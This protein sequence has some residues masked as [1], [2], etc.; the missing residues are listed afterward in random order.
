MADPTKVVRFPNRNK[1]HLVWS[2]TPVEDLAEKAQ[3][4]GNARRPPAEPANS[5]PSGPGCDEATPGKPD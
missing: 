4:P 3:K 2:S 1:L 5:A